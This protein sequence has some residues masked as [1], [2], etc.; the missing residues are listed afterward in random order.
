M[1]WW[2]KGIIGLVV[3]VIVAFLGLSAFLGA[4]A[5]R[6]ER[7]PVTISPAD[8]GL[9]YEDITFPSREDHLTLHGWF[10][11]SPD[12]E[13]V[14][15]MLHGAESNRSDP[16]VNMMGIAAELIANDYNVLMFDFR[17]HGESEGDRLSAGYHERKDLLGA[18]DFV[19]ERGFEQIG[20][21]GFSMGAATALMG[22]AEETNI[23]CIVADSSFADMTG[24]MEREFTERTKFP[25]FFLTPV[26]FMVN[27][28][29]GVDFKAVKPVENVPKIAP[30]P[31]LFI[32]G[33]EDDF[34]PLDHA[35]RLY[36]ASQNPDDALWIV[37]GADHVKAYVTSPTE[38]IDKVIAFFD[39]TLK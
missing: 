35:Y 3:L 18:V 2:L 20:V 22:T 15:I 1:K 10:L 26:L 19:Q 23:D 27:I 25:G 5:T 14:I 36:E 38:Y 8:L 12:S 4:S 39:N 16:G 24:I 29:Y 21:L 28:M 34:T 17:G 32:R 9:D 7:I 31:I 13:Q 30:R 37:P 11:P 6:V 33:E